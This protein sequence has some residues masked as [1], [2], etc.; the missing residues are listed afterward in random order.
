MSQWSCWKILDLYSQ[1]KQ[2]MPQTSSTPQQLQTLTQLPTPPVLPP[3]SKKVSPQASP[4]RQLKRAHIWSPTEESEAPEPVGSK[5]PRLEP[6]MP[7]LP[8]AQP[9][10]GEPTQRT[11]RLTNS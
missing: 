2:Q 7:P 4:P 10:S 1:G 3:L 8:T 6:P 5:I 9:L 11:T